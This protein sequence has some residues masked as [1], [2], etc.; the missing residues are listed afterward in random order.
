MAVAREWVGKH[1]SAA[2]DT[3]TTI[4]ELLEDMFSMQSMQTLYKESQFEL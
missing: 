4:E 2:T 3:H 1:I